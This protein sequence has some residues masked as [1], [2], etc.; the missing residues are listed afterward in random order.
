MKKR[1]LVAISFLAI[2]AVF[3]GAGYWALAA[4][5]PDQQPLNLQHVVTK[6]VQG[7]RIGNGCGYSGA[8]GLLAPGQTATAEQMISQDPANC[9]AVIEGGVPASGPNQPPDES[10]CAPPARATTAT[11]SE[12]AS[13]PEGSA[14]YSW[15]CSSGSAKAVP[16]PG[17]EGQP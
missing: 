11:G 6:T 13:T 3:G 8:L 12:V 1:I 2:A 14:T 9:T 4:I 16:I 5:R 7:K 15:A 17:S 10:P